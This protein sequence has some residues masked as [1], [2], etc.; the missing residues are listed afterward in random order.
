MTS[1]Q[2][3]DIQGGVLHPL[4]CPYVGVFT[5]L[6]IDNAESGRELLAQLIPSLRTAEEPASP[7]A[8]AWLSVAL[9]YKGM[10]AL[11]AP[12]ASLESFA[13]EFRAGMAAQAD[14]L[15]DVG[16]S[17]PTHWEAPLG[18]PDVHMVL[19]SMAPDQERLDAQLERA[20]AMLSRG[21]ITVL[22]RLDCRSS[23]GR[24]PFGF[25]DN[26]SH[27][28]VEGSGIPG[29]NPREEPLK[30]G[31]FILGYPDES[32]RIPPMPQPAALGHNGSYLVIRKLH[33]RVAAFRQY[34]REQAAAPGDEELVAAKIMGRWRSG[35]PL[36]LAPDQDDPDLGADPSRNNDFAFKADGD[37]RGLKCPV[38]SH[39]RRMN[40][41]DADVVGNPRRHRLLRREVVYGPPLPEG[42][43]EDDAVD[44]GMIF[45]CVGASL[46]RQFEFV[47]EEWV[48]SGIFIGHG[49]EK[50]PLCGANQ[51]E[52]VFTIP[53]R[54]IRRRL[55]ELPT[56]VVTRGGDYFFMPSFTALRWLSRLTD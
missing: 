35:A 52:G 29:S 22:Y 37:E 21:G 38:G 18:S 42:V 43:V 24:E 28:A 33:Q 11:G 1:L 32:G 53:E 3:E 8:D 27:P 5:L 4:P 48:N 17:A 7:E 55:P 51:G 34:V 36:T 13:P 12:Q 46:R 50:D 23:D 16:E 49:E 31:E 6:R 40:P 54:P 9:T 41:R 45:A 26:V 15:H 2:L 14:R 25:K 10:Q 56:F 47:Q 44:R 39:V 20:E 19:T 30:A